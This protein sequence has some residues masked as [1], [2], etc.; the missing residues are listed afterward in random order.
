MTRL[1]T[2]KEHFAK[3]L[4][5]YR[6]ILEKLKKFNSLGQVRE[7]SSDAFK[8]HVNLNDAHEKVRLFHDREGLF[9]QTQQE[10]P[11]LNAIEEEFAPFYELTTMA[12]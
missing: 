6:E 4:E 8:L 11:E 7:F 5:Q 10:Y 12:Y 1:D 9:N 3:S 2:E